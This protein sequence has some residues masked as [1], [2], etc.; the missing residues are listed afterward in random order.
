MDDRIVAV[1]CLC[2]DML[3]ALHHRDDPQCHMG[4]AEVMTVA[5]VAALF[6]AGK[7]VAAS[8]FLAEYG[9]MPRMV[10]RS[11]FNR[12]LHRVKDLFLTL[13]AFLGEQLIVSLSPVV[14]TFASNVHGGIRVSTIVGTSPANA[15]I[16]TGC[17]C[18]SW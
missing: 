16:S 15:A 11:R 14:T 2:A 9:Y 7:Y 12:R 4:D 8:A 17:G 6:F 1:Y 10:S 18:T 3:Q 13:F 5:L